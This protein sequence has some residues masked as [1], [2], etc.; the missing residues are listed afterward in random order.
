MAHERTFG[1]PQR[2][3]DPPC[4]HLRSKAIY[5]TGDPDPA[6]PTEIG[7]HRY[8]CWCNKTQ[9]VVGPD[10]ALVDRFACIDGRGCFVPRG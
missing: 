4:L 6:D 10:D 8:N 3:S 9:R 5:V 1:Q 2:I 7:S